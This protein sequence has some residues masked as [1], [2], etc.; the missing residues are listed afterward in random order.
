MK[1]MIWGYTFGAEQ[2][3]QGKWIAVGRAKGKKAYA[4]DRVGCAD[5]EDEMARRLKSWAAHVLATPVLH[6]KKVGSVQQAEVLELF[7]QRVG[8]VV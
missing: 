5:T 2:T 3:K 7:P 8:C 1:Y 6:E 4:L